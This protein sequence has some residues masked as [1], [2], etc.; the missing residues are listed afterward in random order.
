MTVARIRD[1]TQL[2]VDVYHHKSNYYI[3]PLKVWNRYS[4]TMFL[5]QIGRASCRERVY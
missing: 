4:P 5:P 1:T 2:L 3:H